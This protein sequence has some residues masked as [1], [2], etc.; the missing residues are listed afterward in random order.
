MEKQ[1][2]ITQLTKSIIAVKVPEGAK[3]FNVF[4]DEQPNVYEQSYLCCSKVSETNRICLP[5]GQWESI[6]IASEISEEGAKSIVGYQY[7]E[8]EEPFWFVYVP[9]GKVKAN[10]F[11]DT[12]AESLH[13]LLESN[14]CDKNSLI[15]RK[16]K[17]AKS[18]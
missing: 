13:S 10:I 18:A 4:N 17:R 15:L 11:F 7:F 2:E 8:D 3:D 12:A 5:P 16:L 14:E 9:G 6:G 1:P